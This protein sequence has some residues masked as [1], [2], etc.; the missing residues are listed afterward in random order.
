[1]KRDTQIT[2]LLNQGGVALRSYVIEL[3]KAILRLHK[4]VAKL[5]V[6]DVSNQNKIKALEK[7]QPKY[8]YYI[9]YQIPVA[10]KVN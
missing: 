7:G 4:Q 6:Q 8:I 5:Q 10:Q 2:N 3:E 1:M 9:N